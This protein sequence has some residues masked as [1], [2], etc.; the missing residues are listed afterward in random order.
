[1]E[2]FINNYLENVKNAL[3]NGEIN[4]NDLVAMGC[5]FC[6]LQSKCA[7]AAEAGDSRECE[8]FIREETKA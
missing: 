6:P 4:I 2:N 5:K 8:Q 1:M 3:E 7:A